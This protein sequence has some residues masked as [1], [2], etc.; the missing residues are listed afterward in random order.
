M[1]KQLREA[2][3]RVRELPE[4]RQQAAAT[5]LLDF[6][7][8]DRDVELTPA[9]IAEIERRLVEDSVATDEDVREFFERM[10]V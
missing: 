10:K 4:D 5:M 7:D 2:I 8:H 1:N 6:L 3:A 9:Q